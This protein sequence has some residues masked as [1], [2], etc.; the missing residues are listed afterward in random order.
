MVT[1]NWVTARP[2]RGSRQTQPWV[3]ANPAVGQPSSVNS[4]VVSVVIVVLGVEDFF[5]FFKCRVWEKLDISWFF[6]V[7]VSN[8]LLK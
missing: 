3:T 5:F 1:H 4:P 6:V 7:S 8:L 2:S